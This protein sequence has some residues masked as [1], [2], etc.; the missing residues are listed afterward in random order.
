MIEGKNKEGGKTRINLSKLHLQQ[1][2]IF[3]RC[4]I[5]L[6][7]KPLFFRLDQFHHVF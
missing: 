2:L 6:D 5:D 7:P 3:L 1:A 4:D